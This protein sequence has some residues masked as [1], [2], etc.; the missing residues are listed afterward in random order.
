MTNETNEQEQVVVSAKLDGVIEFEPRETDEKKIKKLRLAFVEENQFTGMSE[1]YT[2]ALTQTGDGEKQYDEKRL[3][4]ALNVLNEQTGEEIEVPKSISK[5]SVEKVLKPIK[6][7]EINLYVGTIDDVQYDEES[8][9]YKVVGEKTYHSLYPVGQG[10]GN[11]FIKPTSSVSELIESGYSEGDVL[12]VNPIGINV[13][14]NTKYFKNNKPHDAELLQGSETRYGFAG[15]LWKMLK[16]DSGEE[17][18]KSR[19]RLEK[20]MNSAKDKDGN[21]IG[22]TGKIIQ[23][24]NIPGETNR[25]RNDFDEVLMMNL[26][27]MLD[28]RKTNGRANTG[29]IRLIFT[30]DSEGKDKT[31]KSRQLKESRYPKNEN[32]V[33]TFNPDDTTF[34]EFAKFVEPLYQM[35]ALTQEDFEEIKQM[36]SPFEITGKLTSVIQREGLIAKV[37]LDSVGGSNHYVNVVGF[38]F[39]KEEPQA[40]PKEETNEEPKAEQP[41]EEEPKEQPKEEPKAEQPEEENVFNNGIDIDNDDLPF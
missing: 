27:K 35:G 19:E 16:A 30:V 10:G 26:D 36:T 6:G 5:T 13:E 24:I 37:V 14:F 22:S 3:A 29:S 31:F 8:S 38:E 40:E 9:S 11:S 2:I 34:M 1:E 12:H 23:A 17:A 28:D 39:P 18:T 33:T 21:F 20:Y 15:T 7:K 25:R 4:K 32:Y 41:K